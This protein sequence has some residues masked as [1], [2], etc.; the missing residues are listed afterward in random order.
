MLFIDVFS[1]DT[2]AGG[3]ER[4]I[5]ARAFHVDVAFLQFLN[6]PPSSA[7]VSDAMTF[8]MILHYTCTG[9]L[10]GGITV[11]GV[12]DFGPRENIHL[13][14]CVPLVMRCRIRLNIYGESFCFFYIILLRLD[15][16]RCSFINVLYGSQF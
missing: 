15:V 12:M 1:V 4:P 14:S 16:R 2:G 11:I 7:S 3:C 6:N 5:S 10:S 9:P 13:L 8:I